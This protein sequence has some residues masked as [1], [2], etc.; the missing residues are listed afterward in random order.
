MV[1]RIFF[2]LLENLGYSYLTICRPLTT[3]QKEPLVRFFQ[4]M[5]QTNLRR[6]KMQWKFVF[7]LMLRKFFENI[8]CCEI[9]FSKF[10]FRQNSFFSHF[11]PI[12]NMQTHPPPLKSGQTLKT[13]WKM[14][15]ALNRVGKIIKKNLRYSF[16][17]LSRNFIENW[18]DDVT[19]MTITWKIK[20]RKIGNLVFLS[21]QPIPDLS[22]KF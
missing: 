11:F 5:F 3:T 17:K 22:Y 21:I 14:W 2:W 20:N 10:I 4:H 18:G 8:F 13:S 12:N 9:F 1:R 15:N 16:F 6:K 19:K 7:F